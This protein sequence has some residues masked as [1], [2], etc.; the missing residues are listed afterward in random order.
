MTTLRGWEVF[1]CTGRL[2]YSEFM[3]KVRV[4]FI[5]HGPSGLPED[6]VVN[7]FHFWNGSAYTEDQLQEA[8][9][10]VN[11]FYCGID[12]TQAQNAAIGS[13]LSPW[14][15]R[16]AELRAYNLDE[17]K[18]RTPRIEPVD[19]PAT[20]MSQGL[21][22]EVCLVASLTGA[23]PLGPRRRGRLYIGP[24]N[25]GAIVPG[26][27]NAASKPQPG[28]Q[29]DLAKACKA[30]CNNI[31]GGPSWSIRSTKPTENFVPIVSGH[32]DNAFDTQIRRGPDATAREV[33][34]GAA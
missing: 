6:R 31:F 3:T 15:S 21:P 34:I 5:G 12:N 27:T 20:A 32:V 24:L 7:T 11:F 9:T 8:M 28:F 4:M 26:A 30:L 2:A 14:V 1:P 10:A 33:W 29:Q 18:Q 22:E 17:P 19:L 23:P 25:Y 13:Y 16:T